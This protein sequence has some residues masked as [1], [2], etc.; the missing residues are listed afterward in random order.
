MT[1][2]RVGPGTVR[3]PRPAPRTPGRVRHRQCGQATVEFALLLPQITVLL[4]LILQVG[5]VIN[6]QLLVTHAA[7]EAARAA[8]VDPGADVAMVAA[9]RSG[10][11]GLTVTAENTGGVIVVRV[12]LER[13]LRLPG[14][15]RFSVGLD[16]AAAMRIES[17]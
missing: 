2:R 8:A 12:H 14:L 10:L 13:P 3:R 15:D 7:R 16:A 1:H 5:L 11:D 4:L 17:G 6:D 9:A